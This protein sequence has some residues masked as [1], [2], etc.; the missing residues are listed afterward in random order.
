[1]SLYINSPSYYSHIHG[2]DDEIY[3]MCSLICKNINIKNYTSKLDSIG[4][5]PIIAPI[6]VIEKGLFKE[7]KKI[8]LTY[9]FAALSLHIDYEKYLYGD[10]ERQKSLILDNIFRSLMV[11]KKRLGASFDY[12]GLEKDILLIISNNI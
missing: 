4:I 6:N 8:S 5:T 11:V 9:R 1:M 7:V 2:V 12:D 10:I 3:K